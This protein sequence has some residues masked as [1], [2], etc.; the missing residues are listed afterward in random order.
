MPD[1]NEEGKIVFS[2]YKNGGYKIAIIDSIEYYNDIS[3]Q[4]TENNYQQ[5]INNIDESTAQKYQ[6]NFAQMFI[7]PRLMVD[8]G[9]VKPGLYFYS[10]EIL[11]KLSLSG[12]ISVNFDKDIDF[13][14]NLAFRKLY[15][16]IYTDFMY[17]TRNTLD[18]TKYS[19]YD[20][21]D[22]LRFRFVLMQLGIQFPFFGSEPFEIY[23]RWQRYRAFIK[24][25]IR[26]SKP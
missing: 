23:S 21:D 3:P 16:T 8:Y 1:V 11:D 14:F 15:P 4:L 13:G 20:I 26:F 24:E 10:S 9:T 22:Q 25:N 18:K 6:D 19:V 5:P 2:L 12:G 17:S 7:I